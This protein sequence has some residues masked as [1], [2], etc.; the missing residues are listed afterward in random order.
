MRFVIEQVSFWKNVAKVKMG[1]I[2]ILN[3]GK[4]Q[5][6]GIFATREMFRVVSLVD[7]PEVQGRIA[8]F[9]ATLSGFSFLRLYPCLVLM[10]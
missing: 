10:V 6:A 1:E 5:L 9:Q 8:G 7:W 4:L 3:P 2:S